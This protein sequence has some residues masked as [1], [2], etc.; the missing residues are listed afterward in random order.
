MQPYLNNKKVFEKIEILEAHIEQVEG[1]EATIQI[2]E[3][4]PGA[5]PV[6]RQKVAPDVSYVLQQV[7]KT[8]E[9]SPECSVIDCAKEMKNMNSSGVL[10]G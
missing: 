6:K 7:G 1:V 2:L 10:A 9:L 4:T 3:K 8:S 5:Q